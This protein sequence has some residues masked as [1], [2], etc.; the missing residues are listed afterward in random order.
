MTGIVLPSDLRARI[1]SEA[2]AAWP[3]ECCG[4]LE[5]WRDGAIFRVTAL[6]PTRNISPDDDR[7]DIDPADHVRAQRAARAAGN[8]IVGCYHSHP[9]GSSEPSPRDYAGASQESF[10]WI[11]AA[12]RLGEQPSLGAYVFERGVFSRAEWTATTALDPARGQRV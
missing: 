2:R 9:N 5:G 3:R 10:F 12:V 1:E 6:R 11:V 7:F 4:L 8:A